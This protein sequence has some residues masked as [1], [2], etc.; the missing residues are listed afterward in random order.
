[1]A[2]LFDDSAGDMLSSANAIVTAAPFTICAWFRSDDD[3]DDFQTI[4]GLT[5]AGV[6]QHFWKVRLRPATPKLEVGIEELASSS[7]T[8]ITS[9]PGAGNWAHVA[10]VEASSTDHRLFLNGGSKATDP[11]AVVPAGIDTTQIGVLDNGSPADKF[12]GDIGHYAMW[13]VALS[14]SEV[15]TLAQGV[16]PLRVRRDSLIG[17]WPCN[18]HSPEFNVMGTGTNMTVTGTTVSEEP[19]VYFSIVAPG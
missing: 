3:V 12:S 14:D 19:P 4:G 11:T 7:M 6:D 16:S 15:A 13:N 10:F 8:T 17:Y 9:A 1:M 5:Q 18:G 2:R